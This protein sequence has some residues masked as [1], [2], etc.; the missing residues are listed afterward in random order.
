MQISE[1]PVVELSE[2]E[3]ERGKPEPSYHHGLVQGRLT[4]ALAL[5]KR[6]SVLSELTLELPDG[7]SITPDLSVYLPIRHD[8]NH[9]IIRMK[10]M[11][12]LAVE[13]LTVGLTVQNAL[14]RIAIYFAHGVKSAWL[15]QPNEQTISI[16][17]PNASRPQ[18]FTTGEARDPVTG[19]TAR[20]E[21]I[22][23]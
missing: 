9:D 1:A 13:I 2:Y 22:F 7:R 6:Y 3:K 16:D 20:L 12:L 21:E 19:L 5:T 8:W 10:Q 23:A 4:G 14:E 17:L 15:V 11:P 18:V